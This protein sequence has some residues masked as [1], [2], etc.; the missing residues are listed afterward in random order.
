MLPYG[1]EFAT[2]GFHIYSISF[3]RFDDDEHFHLKVLADFS[4]PIPPFPRSSTK[5]ERSLRTASV[6]IA[7][8]NVVLSVVVGFIALKLGE[9]IAKTI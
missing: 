3:Q 5:Q 7:M 6:L 2:V 8:L 4:A 1:A 9:V